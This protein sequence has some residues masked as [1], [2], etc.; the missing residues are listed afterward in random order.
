MTV[1]AR[2]GLSI[3]K[4]TVDALAVQTSD[5]VFWDRDL[6]GFG[7]RVYASGRKVYVAQARAHS[8]PRRVAL[9]QH[10]D[11]TADQARKHAAAVIDRIKK[12]EDPT[13]LTVQSDFTVLDL[14][15]DT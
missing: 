4:R 3:S 8:V 13:A 10:G 5:A 1:P 12:G 6:P 9:G 14:A 11:I 15:G 7:V 2:T